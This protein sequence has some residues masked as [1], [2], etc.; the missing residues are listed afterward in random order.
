V[1]SHAGIEGVPAD[2]LVEVR[3]WIKAGL[4]DGWRRSS[5]SCEHWKRRRASASARRVMSIAY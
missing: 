3:R 4:T 2:D 5:T 1:R